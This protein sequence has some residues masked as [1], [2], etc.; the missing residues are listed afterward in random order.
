MDELTKKAIF[1]PK[2]HSRAWFPD[3]RWEAP[4]FTHWF[5]GGKGWGTSLGLHADPAQLQ[6][7]GVT[8]LPLPP[9]LHL[10]SQLAGCP[11]R[12]GSTCRLIMA[13]MTSRNVMSNNRKGKKKKEARKVG[14]EQGIF[15]P[16]PTPCK[17]AVT[18]CSIFPSG[19]PH[20]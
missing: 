6:G 3:L 2:F 8:T 16:F 18:A 11:P 4:D 5:L 15:L 19:S 1:Y 10:P 12:P 7:V 9:Q 20:I 13:G 17:P 14:D